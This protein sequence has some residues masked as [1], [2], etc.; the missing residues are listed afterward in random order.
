MAR[1]ADHPINRIAELV[2]WNVTVNLPAET[3][4]AG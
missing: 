4:P 3:Q 1:I 2:L